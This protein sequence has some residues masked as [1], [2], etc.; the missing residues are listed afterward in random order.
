VLQVHCARTKYRAASACCI[1]VNVQDM[2]AL[3]WVVGVQGFACL[4][5]A[6]HMQSTEVVHHEYTVCILEL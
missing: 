4:Y 5:T 6:S 2:H 1:W 3:L